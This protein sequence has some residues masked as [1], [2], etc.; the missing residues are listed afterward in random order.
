MLQSH[1]RLLSLS[2]RAV[3]RLL[4]EAHRR[5]FRSPLDADKTCRPSLQNTLRKLTTLFALD[6]AA[7]RPR[8]I[9]LAR[10]GPSPTSSYGCGSCVLTSM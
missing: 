7:E 10:F 6:V 1:D 5:S 2:T 8:D 9:D 4:H 3:A